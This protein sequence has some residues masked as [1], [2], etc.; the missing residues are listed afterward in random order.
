[1]IL[2][3]LLVG[4]FATP[5]GALDLDKCASDLAKLDTGLSCMLGDKTPQCQ[6]N[7]DQ[8]FDHGGKVAPYPPDYSGKEKNTPVSQTHMISLT[9]I[10]ATWDLTAVK[11]GAKSG[12]SYAFDA[13]AVIRYGK[14][15]GGAMSWGIWGAI[16]GGPMVV[17]KLWCPNVDPQDFKEGWKSWITWSMCSKDNVGNPLARLLSNKNA[18]DALLHAPTGDP[19]YDK[20]R[21]AY[22]DKISNLSDSFT[23]IYQTPIKCENGGIG[24]FG[25]HYTIHDGQLTRVVSPDGY[26]FHVTRTLPLKTF[27]GSDKPVA[28]SSKRDPAYKNAQ[29]FIKDIDAMPAPMNELDGLIWTLRPKILETA[30]T[31]GISTDGTGG[32]LQPSAKS[33]PAADSNSE[34]SR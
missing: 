29:S 2:I 32:P 13:F 7:F 27:S 1:M 28:L 26:P 11:A 22:C 24:L 4:L 15:F 31:C 19:K 17:D 5:A 8:V 10:A 33:A 25:H 18:R 23:K 3:L 6:A 12:L 21:E 14:W 34:I 9:T 30:K 20:M 16:V